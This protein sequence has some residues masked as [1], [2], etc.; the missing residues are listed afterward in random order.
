MSELLSYFSH[1]LDN[2]SINSLLKSTYPEQIK[3]F[4]F[5]SLFLAMLTGYASFGVDSEREEVEEG[6]DEDW[7]NGKRCWRNKES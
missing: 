4:V 1:N 3:H 7:E 2:D 5:L 6:E